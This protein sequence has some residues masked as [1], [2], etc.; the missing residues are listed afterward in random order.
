MSL[1]YWNSTN[2]GYSL[3]LRKGRQ[4]INRSIVIIMLVYCCNLSAVFKNFFFIKTKAFAIN[5]LQWHSKSCIFSVAPSS[6]NEL[7]NEKFHWL[8]SKSWKDQNIINLIKKLNWQLLAF[9]LSLF[10][11][12]KTGQTRKKYHS[13]QPT[14]PHFF[15][16]YV[17]L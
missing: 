7:K 2:Y 13:I 8:T 15:S 16:N 12:G 6:I 1:Q 9:S 10:F 14:F 3:K 4:N 5:W 17:S 11:L